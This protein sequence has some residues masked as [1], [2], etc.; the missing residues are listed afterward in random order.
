VSTVDTDYAEADFFQDLALVDD[1]YGYFEHLRSRGPVVP[2]PKHNVVAVVGYD[3]ATAVHLDTEHFSAVNSPTGPLPPIGFTPEGDDITAQIEAHRPQFPFGEEVLTLDPP[4]HTPLR[5]LMMRV[6]NPRRLKE[7]EAS[8]TR[9]ADQLI[10]EVAKAGACELMRAYATPYATLAVADLLG[11]PEEE[12]LGFRVVGVPM[13]VGRPADSPVVNPMDFRRE[14]FVELI[15]ER[16]RSPRADIMSELA[17]TTRADGSTPELMDVVRIATLLFGAGQDTSATLIGNALRIVAERPDLQA[18]LRADPALIPDFIEEVLRHSGPVKATFRLAKKPSSLAGVEIAPGATV[19]IT[20]AAVNRDPR[21]F[22]K[23]AEFQLGRSENEHLSFGRG[24]HGCP[25][26]PLARLE[27][28]ITLE[29]WLARFSEIS[30]DP[31]VHGPA[32]ARRFA[33][34]PTYVFRTLQALNLRFTPAA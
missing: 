5:A 28:R 34:Q 31:D 27:T 2:L 22:E 14:K 20:T 12:R 6:F 16:R 17:N 25:G 30:L 11:V 29:R 1:P 8:L 13:Q 18:A 23:P 3:E 4:R 10:D 24:V 32:G 21:K 33:Y 26:A 9:L 15:E 7:V 19:M